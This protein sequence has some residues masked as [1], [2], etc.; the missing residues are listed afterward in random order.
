[1]LHLSC[2]RFTFSYVHFVYANVLL[3]ASMSITFGWKETLEKI[4]P[5]P[6]IKRK[7][8]PTAAHV[9]QC[10]T[11]TVSR[12]ENRFIVLCQSSDSRIINVSNKSWG[13]IENC[14]WWS[15]RKDKTTKSFYAWDVWRK[16]HAHDLE[17]Y[18]SMPYWIHAHR[19][20]L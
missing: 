3:L 6:W 17:V 7:A 1:M 18:A 5:N 11:R 14:I 16:K 19:F 4:W 12:W 20:L 15:A 9:K 13:A 2:T 8:Y 10:H